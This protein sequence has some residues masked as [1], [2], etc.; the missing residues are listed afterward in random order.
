M[1]TTLSRPRAALAAA[2]LLVL[3]GCASVGQF[4]EE[5]LRERPP[6]AI[7]R[8]ASASDAPNWSA[9][10]DMSRTRSFASTLGKPATS[11]MYF[12]G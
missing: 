4:L 9:C 6:A 8:M 1:P 12:S 3:A 5:A 2:A 10:A 7:D 11:K